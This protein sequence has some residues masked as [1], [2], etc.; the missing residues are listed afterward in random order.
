M[1]TRLCLL[2]SR[3]KGNWV[4]EGHGL[5]SSDETE[6]DD[7]GDCDHPKSFSKIVRVSHL[8]DEAGEGDLADEGIT[9]VEE[10]I[11]A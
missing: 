4:E 1:R 10:G 2:V 8:G 9:D 7:F 5:T 6:D 3:G 11:H